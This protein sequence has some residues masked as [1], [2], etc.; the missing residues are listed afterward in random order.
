M[1]RVRFAASSCL[2]LTATVLA[3]APAPIER[4]KITDNDLTCQ[5]SGLRYSA[6]TTP[7]PM[8]GGRGAS[9]AE[10]T[11]NLNHLNLAVTDVRAA[12]AF[13]ERYFG[14]R[15]EGGNAG[16]GFLRDERGFVLSL[17]KAGKATSG[18]ARHRSRRREPRGRSE[19]SCGVRRRG[20]ARG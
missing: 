15:S 3:Q 14:M 4:V 1:R 13:L 2:L 19:G 8:R 10:E 11:M 12:G 7:L 20:T 9:C 18:R 5:A 6:S 16:M 17:M